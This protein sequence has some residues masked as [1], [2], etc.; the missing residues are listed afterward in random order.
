MP[1]KKKK[2]SLRLTL[3]QDVYLVELSKQIGLFKNLNEASTWLRNSF[4]NLI[5]KSREVQ[6]YILT[7]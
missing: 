4:K 3:G 6:M 1:G 5:I 2:T 7:G